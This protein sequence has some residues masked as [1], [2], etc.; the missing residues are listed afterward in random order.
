MKHTKK[1]VARR[2][3][4]QAVRSKKINKPAVCQS[5]GRVA[6]P[7]SLH[8]HHFC[9]YEVESQLKVKWLCV[10]CHADAHSRIDIVDMSNI[11]K[12]L[13][14][15]LRSKQLKKQR[16]WGERLKRFNLWKTHK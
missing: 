7:K 11:E 14:S 5:C 2:V 12:K 1:D 13:D 16:V 9:G 4:R 3:L 10:Q 6:A 8:G 15:V